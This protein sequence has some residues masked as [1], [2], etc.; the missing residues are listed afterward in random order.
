MFKGL[1]NRRAVLL[2]VVSASVLLWPAGWPAGSG[3][4]TSTARACG[5]I[6]EPTAGSQN[7]LFPDTGT[8]Y[9]GAAIPVPPGGYI[10]LTGQFPHARY[11]SFVGYT[12]TLQPTTHLIDTQ[13]V[14][15]PGSTNPF[16]SGADRGAAHRSYTVRILSGAPPAGGGAPNTLYD[17][18]PTGQSGHGFAY[19]IYSP[20]S[21]TGEFGGVP[22]PQITL[23]LAG[24]ARVP[25]PSCPA[26]PSD[27]LLTSTLAGAGLAKWYLP[28]AGLLSAPV[29]VWHKYI[30][31]A[32]GYATFLTGGEHVPPAVAAE[33]AQLTQQLPAG[34]G[35]NPD[36]KYVFTNL[37]HEFG[38]AAVFRAKLPSTPRTLGGEPTM[39][40]AGTQLRYWSMCTGEAGTQTLG[41]VVDEQV[42]LRHGDYTVEVSTA[43]DRPS[44]AWLRRCG[45]T[46]LPWG[47]L[48][49]GLVL[50]RNMLPAPDFRQAIQ[51][52]TPGTEQATMG[53]YY[54][55]GHYFASQ[56]AVARGLR[57][58]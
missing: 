48:P 54:P 8:E 47:P 43:A 31:A 44:D 33:V 15:D 10:E 56:R 34:L 42:A 5:W 35:E 19:R 41:C 29:P 37:S 3:A 57:C 9:L 13:I 39:D 40:T 58:R 6:I 22:A 2:A 53:A 32:N 14:P 27:A 4:A 52:A 20:D 12:S 25:L 45:V 51:D 38:A 11:M 21:G 7:I 1:R 17:T 55:V 50:M 16:L 28:A 36:N 24:G 30:N 49:Q 23:V 26:P 18:S 46:W